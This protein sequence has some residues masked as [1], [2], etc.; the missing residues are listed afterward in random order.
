[1]DVCSAGLG[2]FRG[3]LQS[4]ICQVVHDGNQ[5]EFAKVD[6]MGC[7]IPR[8]EGF[9]PSSAVV[10]YQRVAPRP[11]HPKPLQA[12]V[13]ERA[14]GTVWDLLRGLMRGGDPDVASVRQVVQHSCVCIGFSWVHV[15]V[16]IRCLCFC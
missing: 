10:G 15:T 12:L 4:F 11:Q 5:L 1:M 6:M 13:V 2:G 3:A 7:Y 9:L 8:V 14:E 16:S